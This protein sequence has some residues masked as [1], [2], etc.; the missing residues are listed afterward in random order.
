MGPL[1]GIHCRSMPRRRVRTALVFAATKHAGP[2][3]R[4]PF[5]DSLIASTA[6]AYALAL[7]T[8]IRKT[9]VGLEEMLTVVDI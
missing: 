1:L 3:N 2:S 7:Y 4:A 9:F 6:T 5:A 8:R